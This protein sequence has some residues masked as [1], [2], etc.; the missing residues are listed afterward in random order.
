MSSSVMSIEK[1][2]TLMKG[3]IESQLNYCPLIWIF[4]SKTLCNKTIP[5]HKRGLRTVY[6]DCKSSLNEFFEKNGSFTTYQKMSK[7]YI[8]LCNSHHYLSSTMLNG[9]LKVNKT[10][11][12]S[13]RM[14][15]E[16]YVRNQKTDIILV[17]NN[18]C[19]GIT[20]Y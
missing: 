19:F 6:S 10:R 4:H 16:L 11:S 17:S 15:N 5:I 8:K 14:C 7:V 13:L 20:K 12:Y 9:V 1:C 3:F 2:R 18:V